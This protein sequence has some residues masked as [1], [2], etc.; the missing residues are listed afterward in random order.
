M[1]KKKKIL[2]AAV[3][4]IAALAA[5]GYFFLFGES[6]KDEESLREAFKQL[7]MAKAM[8]NKDDVAR[9]VSRK[10][11]DAGMDY[12]TLIDEF[13]AKRPG[14]QAE[15]Q[16]VVMAEGRADITYTRKH[17]V[18]KKLTETKI[19][20]ETWVK[21]ED[22]QWRLVKFSDY[23]RQNLPKERQSRKEAEEKLAAD[24]KARED[25]E[26]ALRFAGYTRT[27]K[28]DPFESLVVETVSEEG[29]GTGDVGKMCDPG[30]PRQFLE[31]F[32]LFSFKLVGTVYAKGYYALIE[33][34]NKNGYTVKPGMYIGRRCGKITKISENR[35][36]VEEQYTNT[37]GEFVAKEAELRLKKED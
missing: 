20:G 9:L 18:E 8:G 14:Y 33:G 22:G 6:G 27:G 36:L 34:G 15:V 13:G 25:A 3:V 29:S 19:P 11:N 37:R 1:D 28:R 5:A 17:L 16:S 31:G 32:D 21:E 24:M 26:N 35:I 30:R 4:G 10:F 2:M 7:S 23:D 12:N